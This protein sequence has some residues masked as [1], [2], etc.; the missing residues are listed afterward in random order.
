[1]GMSSV[2]LQYP[3]EP[4]AISYTNLLK[5][6]V[7]ALPALDYSRTCSLPHIVSTV[8]F[9]NLQAYMGWLS[10]IDF[11]MQYLQFQSFPPYT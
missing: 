3:P 1:M 7:P 6:H 9:V 5:Q 4:N 8:I 10:S 11:D 2:T